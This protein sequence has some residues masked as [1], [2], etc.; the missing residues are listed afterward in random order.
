M[1]KLEHILGKCCSIFHIIEQSLNCLHKH[2]QSATKIRITCQAIKIRLSTNFQTFICTFEDENACMRI[3]SNFKILSIFKK[4]F[5]TYWAF[6]QPPRYKHA[7]EFTPKCRNLPKNANFGGKNH[8]LFSKF[9]GESSYLKFDLQNFLG[10]SH[11]FKRGLSCF[12]LESFEGCS[13]SCIS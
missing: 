13:T 12:H 1:V 2:L 11:W 10:K 9:R 3:K 4:N 5:R 8:L 7:H 6:A